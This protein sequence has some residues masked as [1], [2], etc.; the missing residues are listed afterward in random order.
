MRK[1]IVS[2]IVTLDGYYEGPGKDVLAVFSPRNSA[3]PDDWGFDLYNIERMRAADTVVLGKKTFEGFRSYWPDIWKDSDQHETQREISRLYNSMGKVVVSDTLTEDD[4][5]PWTD[6]T[7]VRRADAL[8]Y[9]ADLKTQ[10][11]GEIVIFGSRILWNFLLVNGLVDEIHLMIS[12]VVLGGGTP[13]FQDA[14][15]RVLTLL[16]THGWEESGLVLARYTPIA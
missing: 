10:E 14:G 12:P 15:D 7:I 16:E 4:L 9:I 3:Y 11:G 6:T 13:A 5:S 1:V 8:Q 2:N